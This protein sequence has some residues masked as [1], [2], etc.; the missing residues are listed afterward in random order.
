MRLN[1]L[2]SILVI[3][4]ISCNYSTSGLKDHK[5]TD[6]D[7]EN[8]EPIEIDEI[9][10]DYYHSNKDSDCDGIADFDEAFG[11]YKTQTR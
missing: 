10:T 3:N 5:V 6:Q 1:L 4:L 9:N 11:T 2:L 8:F 7:S